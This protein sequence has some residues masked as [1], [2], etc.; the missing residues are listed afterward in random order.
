ML[1]TEEFIFSREKISRINILEFNEQLRQKEIE[2]TIQKQEQERIHRIQLRILTISIIIVIIAFLL[3]SQSIIVNQRIIEYL[4][5]V[6]LLI[7]F[8]FIDQVLHPI[9]EEATHNS[10]I[11]MLLILVS[12]AALLVPLHYKLEKW[13]IARLVEKNKKIRLTSAKKTIEQLEGKKP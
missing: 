6:V 13:S 9:I 1:E 3:L 10:P 4:G 2:I 7:T 5:I 11:L 8:E 12:I